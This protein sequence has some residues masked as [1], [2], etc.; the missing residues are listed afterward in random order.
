MELYC[1]TCLHHNVE[2]M[3]PVWQVHPC[4]SKVYLFSKRYT[5]DILAFWKYVHVFIPDFSTYTQKTEY[6][7]QGE[8]IQCG[9]WDCKPSH[10]LNQFAQ[11]IWEYS[12]TL[13]VCIPEKL[14]SLEKTLTFPSASVSMV[15]MATE[16]RASNLVVTQNDRYNLCSLLTENFHFCVSAL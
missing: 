3:L 15:T 8:V 10:F 1:K 12:K 2:H 16:V 7:E 13:N 5:W 6:G 9:G 14:S 11:S 4:A